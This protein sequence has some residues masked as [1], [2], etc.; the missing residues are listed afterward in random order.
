MTMVFLALEAIDEVKEYFEKHYHYNFQNKNGEKSE[1]YIFLFEDQWRDYINSIN[2]RL[3]NYKPV[4]GYKIHHTNREYVVRQLK[5]IL[6]AQAYGILNAEFKQSSNISYKF[7]FLKPETGEYVNMIAKRT[8]Y[9]F[10]QLKFFETYCRTKAFNIL[11]KKY[12]YKDELDD[13]NEHLSGMSFDLSNCM[14]VT[15]CMYVIGKALAEEILADI[16]WD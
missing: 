16:Y 12:N 11:S 3:E 1:L 7:K 10:D 13:I 4:H 15:D 5:S 6:M 9:D 2:Y 14:T 8:D